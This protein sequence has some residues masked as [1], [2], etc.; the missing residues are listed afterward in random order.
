MDAPEHM[1]LALAY[2]EEHLA[3][4][5]EF[6]QTERPTSTPYPFVHTPPK[7]AVP[8]RYAVHRVTQ[9]VGGN[10]QGCSAVAAT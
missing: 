6:Q 2:I 8:D 5:I 9:D 7:P 1:N 3:H 10:R 4:E